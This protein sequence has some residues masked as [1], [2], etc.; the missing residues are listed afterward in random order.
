MN[1]LTSQL[2]TA[3]L[4][5]A[6]LLLARTGVWTALQPADLLHMA[7]ERL[8]IHPPVQR[9][10]A[11]FQFFG[12]MR[13]VMK[14]TLID[15]LRKTSAARRPDLCA[16]IPLSEAENVP[17]ENSHA[18]RMAVQEALTILEGE[19]PHYAALIRQHFLEGHTGAAIAAAAGISTS[20]V[21]RHLSAA[22]LSLR[23]IMTSGI[24]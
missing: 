13:A 11:P 4:R 20:Q 3:L 7:V 22:L 5:H 12:L 19:A 2:Y 10:S 17:A 15:E 14:N 9:G 1:W 18:D 23:R 24:V 21:S 6:D 16:A 8:I